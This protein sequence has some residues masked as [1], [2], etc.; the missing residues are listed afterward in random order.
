MMEGKHSKLSI[1][2]A[3]LCA[4]LLILGAWEDRRGGSAGNGSGTLSAATRSR[5]AAVALEEYNAPENQPGCGKLYWNYWDRTAEPWCVDFLYYCGDRLGLVGKTGAFGPFVADCPSAWAQ[6]KNQGA[7][8]Y[9]LGELEPEAGDIVFWYESTAGPPASVEEVGGLCHVGIVLRYAE[10]QLTTIEGNAGGGGP[11]KTQVVQNTYTNLTGQ[12]WEGV[13]LWGFARLTAG[14]GD[15]TEMVKHFEGFSK[16]PYWDYAQYS[17]GYGTRCPWDKL[18]EYLRDGIPEEEALA[19][20]EHYLSLSVSSV[21]AWL[22]EQQLPTTTYQRDALASLT[23]NIGS[24]WMTDNTY[25][26]FR[27]VITDAEAT[28]LELVQAFAVI[29][30]AGGETLYGLVERRICEAHLF[31]HGE[32]IT[33]YRESGYT[34]TVS[35]NTVTVRE[36]GPP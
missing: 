23:Y 13:S 5:L 34:Y 2:V 9:A 31:L 26:Y 3:I 36:A 4:V 24:G 25:A 12:A 19:L 16:Y 6:L 10:G 35:N 20:L 21:D 30:K 14:A 8:L 15:L 22:A 17:I 28:E 33:D 7:I 27:S 29:S 1:A 18:E 32:Y 11:E